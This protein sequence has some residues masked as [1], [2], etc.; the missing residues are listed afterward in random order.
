MLD[1]SPTVLCLIETKLEKN[2]IDNEVA[3]A[4]Y[5]L[6]RRDRRGGGVAVYCRSDVETEEIPY[7][8]ATTEHC[9]LR[10]FTSR[11]KSVILSCIYRSPSAKPDW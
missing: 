8:P 11:P 3:L 4:G 5:S 10:V 2:V 7:M 6:F 1:D 9:T